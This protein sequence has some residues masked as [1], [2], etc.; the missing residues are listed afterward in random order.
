MSSSTQR[1]IVILRHGETADNAA[2]IWQ[3]HRDSPLSSVG[4]AQ[5]HT[6]APALAALEP[7]F[8][9]ASDLQRARVTAEAVGALTGQEVRTDPRLREIDVGDWSGRTSAQVR[10]SDPEV[11][12]AMGRG[13]DVRR[14]RTGETVAELVTRVDAA[15]ADVVAQLAPGALALV[16]CHGVSGRTGAAALAGL[17][18]LVALQVLW[19]LDN[20]H[21]AVLAEARSVSGAPV[22]PRWRIDAWNVGVSPLPA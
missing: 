9:V 18:Q 14:G 16:V 10:E 21:W 13:E 3:G 5:A 22:A 7:A 6:A 19:G 4:L 11:L 20:C 12:E 8:I 17:D 1:R 15:L 2:G